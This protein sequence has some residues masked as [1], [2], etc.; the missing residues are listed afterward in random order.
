LILGSWPAIAQQVP[1]EI[2]PILLPKK[3]RRPVSRAAISFVLTLD[4][5]NRLLMKSNNA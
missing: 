3:N 5:A 4:Q 1:P 2:L